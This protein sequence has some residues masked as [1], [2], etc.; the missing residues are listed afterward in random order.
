MH[1]VEVPLGGDV[2]VMWGVMCG[3]H[4]QLQPFTSSMSRLMHSLEVAV[5]GVMWSFM[6]GSSQWQQQVS[7]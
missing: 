1:T 5:W 6:R 4:R 3:C 7:P 2:G